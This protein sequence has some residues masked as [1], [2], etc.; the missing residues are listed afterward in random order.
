MFVKMF[1]C[2]YVVLAWCLML[3]APS[4]GVMAGCVVCSTSGRGRKHCRQDMAANASMCGIASMSRCAQ[5]AAGCAPVLLAVMMAGCVLV[6]RAFGRGRI[7]CK[8]EV[9][10]KSRSVTHVPRR[11]CRSLRMNCCLMLFLQGWWLAVCLLVCST[12]WFGWKP[13]AA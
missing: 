11:R 10:Q 8:Q 6:S 3:G 7:H 5:I 13:K 4:V 2:F 12:C 9:L 1:N